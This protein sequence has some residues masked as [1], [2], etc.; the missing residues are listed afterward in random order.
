MIKE[1]NFVDWYKE[2]NNQEKTKEVQT[3]FSIECNKCNSKKVTII[4]SD[5]IG[6]ADSGNYG[7]AGAKFK[8]KECGNAV[9]LITNEA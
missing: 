1:I 2:V 7:D 4:P 6:M 5:H 3:F 8:C 9:R